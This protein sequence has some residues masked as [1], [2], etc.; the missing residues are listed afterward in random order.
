M[1]SQL[2]VFL[3][4][5]WLRYWDWPNLLTLAPRLSTCFSGFLVTLPLGCFYAGQTLS[6]ALQ[7]QYFPYLLEKNK[8]YIAVPSVI[9]YA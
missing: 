2:L 5:F 3:K 9:D 1:M 8:E 4:N 7:A 6:L